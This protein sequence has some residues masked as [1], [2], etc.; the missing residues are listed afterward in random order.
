MKVTAEIRGQQQVIQR[1]RDFTPLLKA[2]VIETVERLTIGL[3]RAVMDE[4]LSGQV[5]NVRSGR[6]RRS[7]GKRT[8]Q[9]FPST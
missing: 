6:L 4:K 3:Q 8:G 2:R 9:R 7:I 1:V 5:L